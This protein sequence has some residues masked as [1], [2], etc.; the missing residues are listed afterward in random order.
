M[1]EGTSGL[2]RW[3]SSEA[4]HWELMLRMEARG[5]P[6]PTHVYLQVRAYGSLHVATPAF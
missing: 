6:L 5:H 3:L 2:E 4:K 1:R